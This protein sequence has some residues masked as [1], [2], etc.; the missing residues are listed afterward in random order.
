MNR[1]KGI[2]S[3]AFCEYL[4]AVYLLLPEG[5]SAEFGWNVKT[6]YGKAEILNYGK[7]IKESSTGTEYYD[8]ILP[9]I[10]SIN[11]ELS[12]EPA[13]IQ[14]TS[15]SAG[16]FLE[17]HVD[18]T[19]YRTLTV[20]LNNT[21]S[22]GEYLLNDQAVDLDIGEGV[23]FDGKKVYHQVTEVISGTRMALNIWFKKS[24]NSLI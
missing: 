24:K 22:G 10:S 17:R 13:W 19:P 3:I 16:S 6:L 23:L 21:Y 20:S 12:I 2:F 15:Y 9:Y 18:R 4:Q 7:P 1:Y 8:K 5:N 14:I 11:S